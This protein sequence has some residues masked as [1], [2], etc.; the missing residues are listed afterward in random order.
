MDFDL[1]KAI[2]EYSR[3]ALAAA[4]KSDDSVPEPEPLPVAAP[5]N[6]EPKPD[7]KPGKPGNKPKPENKPDNKPKPE[8]KPENKPEKKSERV[9]EPE[10]SFDDLMFEEN[11]EDNLDEG[12]DSDERDEN[13]SGESEC[14]S[15]AEGDEEEKSELPEKGKSDK[16]KAAKRGDMQPS[17]DDYI[18]RRNRSWERHNANIRA[19]NQGGAK[20]GQSSRA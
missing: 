15:G 7:N 20:S 8:N 5:V 11:V 3:Q 12:G 16:P 17:F 13:K 1:Q 18:S 9:P 19:K 14:E 2:A 10:F 4:N 6:R